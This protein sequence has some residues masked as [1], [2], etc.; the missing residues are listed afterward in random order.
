LSQYLG[1]KVSSVGEQV[2][3]HMFPVKDYATGTEVKKKHEGGRN[4]AALAREYSVDSSLKENGG[5]VG[6]LPR[7]VLDPR[8]DQVA[9]E[10]ETGKISEPLFVDQQ[11]VVVMMISDR[12]AAREIDEQSLKVIRSKALEAWLREEIPHHRVKFHGFKNGYDNETDAWVRLQL[13]K[14]KKP[15]RPG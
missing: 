8:F 10:L 4:F 12:V 5:A 1:E 13:Q 14:M 3:V 2:F 11:I 6:W 9:F 15:S 7:G